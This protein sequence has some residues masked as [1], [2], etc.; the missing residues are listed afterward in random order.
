[1]PVGQERCP[2]ITVVAKYFEVPVA[3]KRETWD[4]HIARRHPEV[5]PYFDH[6]IST[7]EDPRIIGRDVRHPERV[8]FYRRWPDIS[9][10][11]AEWMQVLVLLEQHAPMGK[12][13]SAWAARRIG[14][15]E[16]IWRA[17]NQT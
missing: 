13:L 8:Y 10:F 16:I 15:K 6:V 5:L 4:E 2:P 1:M 11:P 9:D 12:L 14:G 3:L 17:E 7:I